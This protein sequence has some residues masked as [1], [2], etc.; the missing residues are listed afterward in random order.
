KLQGPQAAEL[1]LAENHLCPDRERV[2]L[3][4]GRSARR[5]HRA[6]AP[7][8]SNPAW[9]ASAFLSA[10]Q[11]QPGPRPGPVIPTP[12]CCNRRR[13]WPLSREMRPKETKTARRI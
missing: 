3:H 4:K 11:T 6:D 1:L 8:E 7:G 2:N 9:G 5:V 10:M 13:L 12:Y